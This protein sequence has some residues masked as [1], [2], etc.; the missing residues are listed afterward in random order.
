MADMTKE[1]CDKLDERLNE[2]IEQ[3]RQKS[4]LSKV[5]FNGTVTGFLLKTGIKLAVADGMG[6]MTLRQAVNLLIDEAFREA[7]M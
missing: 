4:G 3:Y 1:L 2:T 7:G 6:P 5:A